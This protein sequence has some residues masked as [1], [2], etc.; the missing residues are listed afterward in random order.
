MKLDCEIRFAALMLA[1][2][3][4]CA[5]AAE[6]GLYVGCRS[7]GQL[8]PRDEPCFANRK[9]WID[10]EAAARKQLAYYESAQGWAFSRRGSTAQAATLSWSGP[11]GLTANI[12][13]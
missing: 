6:D 1:L 8:G 2:L 5:L 10:L 9:I 13:H 7:E 11:A 3:M 12:L 4:P